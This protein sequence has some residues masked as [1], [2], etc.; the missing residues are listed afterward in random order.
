MTR[1]RQQASTVFLCDSDRETH[2]HVFR[3]A[4]GMNL[5][6]EGFFSGREFLASYDV[7]RPG[8]LVT[9]LRLADLG[10]L[11]IQRRLAAIGASLPVVFLAAHATV[12][13][14]VRA[15]QAGAADFLEK[16]LNEEEAWEAIQDAL[17]LD[18]LRRNELGKQ[19]Q[20]RRLVGLLSPKERRVLCLLGEG[21][22]RC[23]VASELKLSVRTVDL[24]R[25]RAMKKLGIDNHA[26]LLR[27]TIQ[28]LGAGDPPCGQR[29]VG[30][31][32]G[33]VVA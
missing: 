20:Q 32:N 28:A 18:R 19:R 12:P 30:N 15:M 24:A 13:I 11:E 26:E 2:D 27:F 29:S 10:G 33:L 31:N 14:V 9:E 17:H 25:A 16:P 4:G 23:S 3:L 6:F 7:S 1:Q 22:A 8:C 21:K 5:R